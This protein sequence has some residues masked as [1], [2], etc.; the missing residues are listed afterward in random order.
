MGEKGAPT[1]SL[2]SKRSVEVGPDICTSRLPKAPGTGLSLAP[3]P[4][5]E[6]TQ[7]KPGPKV[8]FQPPLGRHPGTPAS[9]RRECWSAAETTG[10]AK[11][12][13]CVCVCVC[14]AKPEFKHV[15]CFVSFFLFTSIVY[16]TSFWSHFSR[17]G[18][19]GLWSP[20]WPR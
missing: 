5:E 7:F 18:R 10:P 16:A 6:K 11:W 1:V 9:T 14:W 2:D 3:L 8:M 4:R 13:W 12:K 19:P 15:L 20:H 17:P